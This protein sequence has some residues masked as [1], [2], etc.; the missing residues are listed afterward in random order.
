MLTLT[1]PNLS[2]AN[3]GAAIDRLQAAF[4]RLIRRKR[5]LMRG[6]SALS[7]ERGEERLRLFDLG[8]LR[9]R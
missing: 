8:K 4:G 6:R 5:R 9:R 2:A 3:F 7:R 1:E